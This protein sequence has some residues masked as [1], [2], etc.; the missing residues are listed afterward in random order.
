LRL[1]WGPLRRERT[2]VFGNYQGR[3]LHQ[4]IVRNRTVL[5]PEI[6][7]GPFRWRAP[8]SSALSQYN[9]FVNDPRGKGL[10]PK[11][12]ELL[13]LLPAPN[14]TDLGDGWNTGGFR[15]NNPNNVLDD[16]FTI[17]GDHN[18]GRTH[19]LFYRHSWMR[20]WGIDS[21]NNADATFPGQ[22]QGSQSGRRW[23]SSFGWD[24]TPGPA[25]VN[26]F[27][28][29]RQSSKLDALRPAR[30]PAPMFL[31]NTYT[32]P[33]A[34]GFPGGRGAVVDD[35]SDNLT[36][37]RGRHTLKT[38]TNIRWTAQHSYDDRGSIPT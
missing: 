15:F 12:G 13:K 5:T 14:N 26:E 35:W 18:A 36:L 10:D 31:A 20:I 21:I 22:P 23:G 4:D 9:L 8:G 25:I 2:F 29:G 38:G 28:Y 37:V 27:R 6:K 7:A 3:R 11:I 32:N 1:V 24:W 19:R 34:T 16:Q 17:R 30:L 33:L